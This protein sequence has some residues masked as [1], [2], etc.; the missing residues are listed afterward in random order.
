[1]TVVVI[2]VFTATGVE[3]VLKVIDGV[4]AGGTIALSSTLGSN[5][6]ECASFT[7][8]AAVRGDKKL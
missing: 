2:P 8:R 1:L 3:Y 6:R 5:A 7:T 4:V